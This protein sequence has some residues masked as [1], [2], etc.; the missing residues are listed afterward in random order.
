MRAPR[1]HLV[2]ALAYEARPLIAGF[3]LRA[4]L[5]HQAFRIYR[6]E[7]ADLVVTGVGRTAAAAGT[8][9]LAAI[10]EAGRLDPWVNVGVGGH[11]DLAPGHA[12]VA[13]EVEDAS[14][15]RRRYPPRTA[16]EGLPSAR[17]RTVERVETE[18][19][20]DAICEMEAAAFVDSAL[21]FAASELVQVLK[22][23]SDGPS[24]PLAQLD[25]KRIEKLVG[26][27]WPL[28]EQLAD[29]LCALAASG[30]DPTADAAPFEERWRFT[31]SQ[32]RRL[33]ALLRRW[34]ALE[35]AD[36]EA[37][38]LARLASAEDASALLSRLEAEVDRMPVPLR[39]L[40][41]EPVA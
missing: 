1:L 25:A 27:A 6:S 24:H 30:V 13:H 38:L 20:T 17:V 2:T 35:A 37:A 41:P 4:D 15:D 10:A 3:G 40:L 16:T 14:S 39:A 26:D 18:W 9:Y 32:R 21:R 7:C 12:A 5:E 28:V 29:R 8:A 11:R 33:G 36:D 23:V 22:I 34:R 19:R 31:V